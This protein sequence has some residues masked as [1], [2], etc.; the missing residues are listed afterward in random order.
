MTEEYSNLDKMCQWNPDQEVTEPSLYFSN[1]KKS[2][3][4]VSAK[5]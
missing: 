4:N 1:S 2:L 3:D 5:A